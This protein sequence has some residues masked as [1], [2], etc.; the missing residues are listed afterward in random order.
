VPEGQQA[1]E[2]FGL[3]VQQQWAASTP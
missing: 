3:F 1:I 2:R